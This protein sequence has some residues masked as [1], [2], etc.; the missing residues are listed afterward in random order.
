MFGI[1]KKITPLFNLI[2]YLTVTL[3]MML[4]IAGEFSLFNKKSS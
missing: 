2:I 1:R 4:K 3:Y